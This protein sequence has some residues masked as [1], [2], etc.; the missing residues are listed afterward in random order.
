MNPYGAEEGI[1][2]MKVQEVIARAI[3]GKISWLTAADVLRWSPRTLRRWRWR[4]EQRGYGGLFD[5]RK[6]RPSPRRVPLELAQ[7]VL[8]LYRQRYADLNVRH[9]HEK[10]AGEHGIKLSYQWVK[11]ALQ[12][13]GLVSKGS[14]HSVH[15]QR[16]ERRPMRGML[17]YVDGSTHA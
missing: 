2:V 4:Y 3:A 13:A 16:R 17:V 7:K 5:R 6:R 1:R 8:G 14:R 11:D 12:A 9:F 15:R 10:L